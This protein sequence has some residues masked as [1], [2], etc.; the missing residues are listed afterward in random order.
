MMNCGNMGTGFVD[1]LADRDSGHPELL[2]RGQVGWGIVDEEA[3]F[4]LLPDG[5]Q[6]DPESL[7]LRLAEGRLGIDINDPVEMAGHIQQIEHPLRVFPIRI[8]E[9]IL[10]LG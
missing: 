8:G 5:I 6:G 9:D 10:W 4:R 1:K 7:G 3:V 2:G